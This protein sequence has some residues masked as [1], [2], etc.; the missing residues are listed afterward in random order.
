M[1]SLRKRA[2]MGMQWNLFGTLATGIL[3]AAVMVILARVI[4]PAEFG[5]LAVAQLSVAFVLYF[6]NLGVA[7]ALIRAKE[8]GEGEVRT[9]FS[10]AITFSFF[11][12]AALWLFAPYSVH[13]MESPRLPGVI[14]AMGV[15]FLLTGL[16]MVSE[17]LLRRQMRFGFLA[18]I[19][20][21]SY[22]IGYF[23]VGIPMALIGYG[24]WALV[25]ALLVQSAVRTVMQ[26]AG[27]RHSIRLIWA[28]KHIK[29]ILCYGAQHS[30]AGFLEFLGNSMDRFC[31]G[32]FLGAASLGIYTRGVS[33]INLPNQ[34]LGI[35]ITR[36]LLPGFSEVQKD[37]ERLRRGYLKGMAA[38]SIL[39]LPFA[40][41]MTPAARPIISFVLGDRW[42]DA[43]PAFI[44]YGYI[45]WLGL[46]GTISVT[47]VDVIGRQRTKLGIEAVVLPWM[48]TGVL[49]AISIG[50]LGRVVL[51]VSLG[52]VLRVNLA[53]AAVHRLLDTKKMILK[54]LAG[55]VYAGLI[56]M[57]MVWAAEKYAGSF[58]VYFW[59]PGA[60]LAGAALIFSGLLLVKI[61]YVAELAE[62]ILES[63]PRVAR[64]PIAVWFFSRI[65]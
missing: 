12:A 14:R 8:L 35:A 54:T 47:V 21:V 23:I 64:L 29:S 17:S 30:L 55:G 34:Y 48:I 57:G 51:A 52:Y 16:G 60:L 15:N 46:L 20:G 50:S 25:A 42:V 7:P 6:S 28:P 10:I 49:F 38:C 2:F 32:K 19:Q 59:L 40:M 56:F 33:L 9:A 37:L 1:M 45:S 4:E 18:V 24:V 11:L 13:M 58:P 27:A 3:Q 41:A 26:Y 22:F 39:M 31:V 36:V 5:V 44:G 63:Y 61:P 43:W 65:K 53:G 62:I